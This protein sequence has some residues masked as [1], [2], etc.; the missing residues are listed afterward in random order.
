MTEPEVGIYATLY[1]DT[2]DSVQSV[3][4][5]VLPNK[6]FQRIEQRTVLLCEGGPLAL[7]VEPHGKSFYMSGRSRLGIAEVTRLL[8]KIS[9]AFL[10]RG[11]AV[12]IEYQEED[13]NANP[14]SPCLVITTADNPHRS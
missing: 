2:L 10:A 8:E 9:A 14:L 12:S 6:A 1:C 5:S 11:I 3:L 13:S 7:S 4:S